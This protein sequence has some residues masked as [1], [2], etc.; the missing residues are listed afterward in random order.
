MFREEVINLNR[1]VR[2]S[3]TK[4]T[5]KYKLL[6]V[7]LHV[8]QKGVFCT[9]IPP[10]PDLRPLKEWYPQFLAQIFVHLLRSR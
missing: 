1:V 5:F 3:L 10:S 6:V 8:P 2:D 7:R 4:V 9:S